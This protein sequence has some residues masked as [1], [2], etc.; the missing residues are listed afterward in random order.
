MI[1]DFYPHELC[2]LT[3]DEL[4]IL[5]AHIR[6]L[7]MDLEPNSPECVKALDLLKH[8]RVEFNRRI[9]RHFGWTI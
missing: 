4:E 9:Q 6:E 5:F 3:D 1:P 7:L 2:R 8:I